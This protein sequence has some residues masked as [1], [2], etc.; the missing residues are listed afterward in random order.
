MSIS[1]ELSPCS[2]QFQ[3]DKEN[4]E[5]SEAIKPTVGRIVWYYYDTQQEE[6]LAAIISGVVADN[7]IAVTVFYP[8]MNCQ[9]FRSVHLQQPDADETGVFPRCVWMPYQEKKLTGSES[10]E[11]AAGTESI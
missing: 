2:V 5:M 7:R 1:D 3:T 4:Q 8:G 11:K 10:G 9:H 6:P